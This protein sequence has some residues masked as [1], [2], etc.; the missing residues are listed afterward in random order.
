M[1][2]FLCITD[3]HGAFDVLEKILCT[4]GKS[5]AILLG[6]DLTHFGEPDDAERVICLAQKY[7]PNVLAVS[8]NCDSLEIERRLVELGVGV[9]G[10]GRLLGEWGIH[11][12]SGAPLWRPRTYEFSEDELGQVLDAGVNT[13]SGAKRHA[14][15][16]HVP[17][18]N[19]SLDRT[20]FWKHVGSTALSDFIAARQPELVVCGH[21]HEARGIERIG[22][23][24]VVN[25][26]S[27]AR[28]YYALAETNQGVCV[29]LH[30]VQDTSYLE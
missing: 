25:C 11:G 29:T 13:L 10:D 17:P 6:G 7:S 23:T 22:Q 3:I 2:K 19:C 27:A 14:V 5:D 16:S 12:L 9:R 26:G 8:G 15:L 21:I 1:T 20:F 18:R 4:A 24:T 28:G 30:R